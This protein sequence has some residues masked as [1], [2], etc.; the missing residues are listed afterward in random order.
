[1]IWFCIGVITGVLLMSMLSISKRA[2][3]MA[4]IQHKRE[5]VRCTECKYFMSCE[6]EKQMFHKETETPC[7][8]FKGAEGK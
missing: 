2:D 3:T 6:S 7:N 5:S 8:N 1:M 4:E